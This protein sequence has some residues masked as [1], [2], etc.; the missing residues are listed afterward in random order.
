MQARAKFCI[1]STPRISA[2]IRIATRALRERE[3][4]N[5]NN[6]NNNKN[7]AESFFRLNFN[8]VH[9]RGKQRKS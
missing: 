3:K 5:N 9:Y 8:C 4:K 6:N 7:K 2:V 1:S